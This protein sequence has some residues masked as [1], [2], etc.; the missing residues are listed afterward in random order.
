MISTDRAIDEQFPGDEWAEVRAVV[1]AK[2]A[3]GVSPTRIGF[4][5]ALFREIRPRLAAVADAMDTDGLFPPPLFSVARIEGALAQQRRLAG[6]AAARGI[7]EDAPAS[8]LLPDWLAVAMLRE[9]SFPRLDREMEAAW[10]ALG[11]RVDA[12]GCW[13]APARVPNH[14]GAR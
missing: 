12:R 4:D 6:L 9:R 11:G 3:E 5:S 7:P 1:R 14:G 13:V 2:A 10:R 8:P